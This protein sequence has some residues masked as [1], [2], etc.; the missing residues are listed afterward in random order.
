M[1]ESAMHK[2]RIYILLGCIAL[3][4][5]VIIGRLY[6]LQVIYFDFWE[7]KATHQYVEGSATVFDRGSVFFSDKENHEVAAATIGRG[8]I[9]AAVPSQIRLSPSAIYEKLSAIVPL[10]R[11]DAIA[12][13]SKRDDPYEV[14]ANRLSE[15]D[16]QKVKALKLDGILLVP[17]QWRLYPGKTQA[18]HTIGF[19]GSIDERVRGTYGIER[20]FDDVLARDD[21]SQTQNFFSTLFGDLQDVVSQKYTRSGDIIT[22][23]EPQVQA[24]LEKDLASAKE[25][26]KS[27]RVIGIVMNPHNGEIVALAALPTFDPNLYNTV[28]DQSLFSNPV[29][30]HIYEMGSIIKVLTFA[31]G[32]DAGVISES[33]TYHDAGS[34]TLDG[35]T[36]YNFD[37]KARNTVSIKEVLRQSLNVGAAH[38]AKLLGPEHMREY[39]RE[40]FKLHE[41][42]GIDLP[43]E[44]AGKTKNLESKKAVEYATASFGQGIALSPI[45]TIRALAAVANG[46]YLVQPHVVKGIHY[47]AGGGSTFDYTDE[48]ERILSSQT[49]EIVSKVLASVVDEKLGNGKYKIAHYSVAAKTGTAQMPKP[50][51]GYYDD[52]YL[53]SFIG[54]VPAYDPQYIILLMNIEPKGAK[55]ASETLADPFMDMVHFLI[56]YY[57]I[58]PDR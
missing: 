6:Q 57:N 58:K 35:Y 45:G 33:T 46:G 9:L 2:Q 26:W 12:H 3:F 27:K 41:E 44:V 29:V 8:F 38:I 13:L 55:Y 11:D 7:R 50:G 31:A 53:H 4:T 25:T 49:S 21:S 40:K 10:E 30:E 37:K 18:A 32:I 24:F 28:T 43:G 42:T 48:K 23:I 34:L 14:L 22:T 39:F 1:R 36:I 52:R 56:N 51:G 47:R 19:V 15:M 16:G 17:E 5:F 54:Y 20:H